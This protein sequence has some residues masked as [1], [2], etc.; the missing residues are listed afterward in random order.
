MKM[1]PLKAI[2]KFCV[3]FAGG[4]QY[5]AIGE[6]CDVP[7]VLRPYRFGRMP[8]KEERAQEPRV[9]KPLAAI[10]SW[11]KQCSHCSPGGVEGC[12]IDDCLLHQYRMGTDPAR[13]GA[14]GNPRL[15]EARKMATALKSA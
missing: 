12:D 9:L 10:K 7:P 1:T 3:W 13:K 14:G 5:A 8:T 4:A 15:A 2:R 11:C 6:K